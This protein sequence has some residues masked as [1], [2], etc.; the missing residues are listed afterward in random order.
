MTAAAQVCFGAKRSGSGGL[1]ILLLG[2]LDEAEQLQQIKIGRHRNRDAG[3]ADQA[4]RPERVLPEELDDEVWDTGVVHAATM[5]TAAQ[6]PLK[7]FIQI[8]GVGAVLRRLERCRCRN[9]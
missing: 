8:L 7:H 4:K 3:E 5:A 2:N 6:K 9:G 1:P